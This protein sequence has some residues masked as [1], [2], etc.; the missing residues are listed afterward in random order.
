MQL[1]TYVKNFSLGLGTAMLVF[2][3]AAVAQTSGA[4][5]PATSSYNQ[6]AQS[7]QLVG[8]N[9]RLD[10][11]LDASSAQQ[12]Q[13]VEAKLDGSVKTASGL[14]LDKG[15]ELMGTVTKARA[16]ADGGPS[17][18][19]V[20]FTTAQLKDGKQI[21][22]KVTVVAAYPADANAEATYGVTSMGP[23]PRHISSRQIIDQ[24]S[25]LLHHVALHSR[26]QGQNSGTF[27][28]RDGNVKLT[29]GTYLQ[30]G[31]APING[32]MTSNGA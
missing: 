24:E 11:T 29:A 23:A 15:T 30:V 20:D 27:S 12:G 13:K 6:S 16:S 26:V 31:I 3:G 7:W 10:H 14:K 8:V 9:A 22:V 19:S 1:G 2:A 4:G 28:K 17:S 18:L 32:T 21:P 25:G 5:E